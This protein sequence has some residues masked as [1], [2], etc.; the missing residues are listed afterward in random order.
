MS[1]S[2]ETVQK[3]IADNHVM[4][5][6]KSYCPYCRKAK[7][8]LDSLNVK[9]TAVELDTMNEGNDLQ[10]ALA[11]LSGQ[12]TVP[13][14]YIEGQHVGGCDDLHAANSSG[15]LKTLLKL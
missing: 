2:K 12:R 15:K 8:L 9:Y 4:V 14:I 10:N 13:N 6:S 11:Q 7:A 5:F 3:Y 1:A